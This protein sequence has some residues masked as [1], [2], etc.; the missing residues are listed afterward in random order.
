M[1]STLDTIREVL[2]AALLPKLTAI[3]KDLQSLRAEVTQSNQELRAEMKQSNQELRAEGIENYR[4]LR[5]EMSQN[6]QELRAEVKQD[7]QE[8]RGDLELKFSVLVNEIQKIGIRTELTAEKFK[9]ETETYVH[10]SI[11]PLAERVAVLEMS[12]RDL[13]EKL[14]KA[15]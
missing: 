12:F 11:T 10:R 8:L 7:I 4:G 2:Q 15:S 3:E 6:N 9:A 14:E 13:K 1:P 5:A